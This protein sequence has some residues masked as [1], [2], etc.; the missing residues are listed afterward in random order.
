MG[1]EESVFMPK[2]TYFLFPP[3]RGRGCGCSP[4]ALG[5]GASITS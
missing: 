2:A 1:P 5:M 3:P 4:D